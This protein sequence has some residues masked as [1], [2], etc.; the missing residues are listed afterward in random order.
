MVIVN[1]LMDLETL[2]EEAVKDILTRYF[3]VMLVTHEE[4][5]LLNASGVRSTMPKDWDRV[6]VF[7]RY[8]AVGIQCSLEPAES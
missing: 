3:K 5:A 6:N 2:T 1:M 4:H 7:S 8:E